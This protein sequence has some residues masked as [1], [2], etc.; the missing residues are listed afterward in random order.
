[1]DN[2]T[3]TVKI[4]DL[5]EMIEIEAEKRLQEKLKQI[6][7]K[8]LNNHIHKNSKGYIIYENN[9]IIN[10]FDNI[11]SAIKHLNE[12]Y[13]VNLTRNTFINLKNRLN[14][15]PERITKID[16]IFKNKVLKKEII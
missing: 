8:L 14:K 9:D 3:I 5:K 12:K 10:K 7:K 4:S 11:S 1:M 13:N 2:L 6:D 16:K 15:E